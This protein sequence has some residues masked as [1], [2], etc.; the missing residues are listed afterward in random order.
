MD[1]QNPLF[2]IL[3]I[4]IPILFFWYQRNRKVNEGLITY[5]SSIFFSK[6]IIK[7]GSQKSNILLLT[8]FIVLTLIILALSRPRLTNNLFETKV[9]IVDLIMVLDISSSMLA[10]DFSPNRLE[11][12]KRTASDFIT[13]RQNDRI[14]ILV[15]AGQSFIQCPLTMDR[16]ILK[17][18]IKE[19]TVASK[20]YDGTA[21]GMAIANATNRLRN[22]EV[23]SKIMILLSDG[24]NNSGEIDPKTATSLAAEYGI[25]IYTIGAGTDQSYTRIPDK[26]LIRNEIDEET[27]RYI[28]DKTGGKYFRATDENALSTIYK[29]I[30]KL[31]K[32]E[33]ET[34]EYIKYQDLYGWFLI[35][36]VLLGLSMEVSR[37][38]LF[39]SIT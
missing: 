7:K 32:S 35:P 36:A 3:L 1:F 8:H 26:G 11:A 15:F 20:E 5:S 37:R 12:V 22:S 24:S 38:I 29:E 33:V 21:I 34:R 27:L 13:G 9:N 30:D 4:F 18:L 39:R 17:S 16:G 6:D 31:E 14:G 25:K 2:L 19:I 23:K 10:D 28:A